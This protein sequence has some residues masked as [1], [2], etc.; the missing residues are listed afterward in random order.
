[1]ST[2]VPPHP[3]QGDGSQITVEPGLIG[4]EVNKI[5]AEYKRKNKL[6]VQYK[7]RIPPRIPPRTRL[8]WRQ[9]HDIMFDTWIFVEHPAGYIH[10]A[11]SRS[12]S[13]IDL[14]RPPDRS[15]PLEHRQLYDRR[16][17]GQ[18]LFW[19]VLRSE[20]EHLPHPQGE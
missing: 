14:S 13:D 9:A 3:S 18:Q 19:D 16:Y 11:H 10:S 15:R 4:G 17:C 5:L 7:V 6:P 2:L 12:R 20:P 1:M 8:T